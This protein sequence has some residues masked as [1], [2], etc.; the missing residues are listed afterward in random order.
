MLK[1]KT[2]KTSTRRSRTKIK[3]Q[4]NKNWS[5]N[6]NN[7]KDQTVV[8][9]G[10]ERRNACRWQIGIPMATRAALSVTKHDKI[11]NYLAKEYFWM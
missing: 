6:T 3:N 10:G 4:N 1:F 2:N 8:F 7:K 9:K 5:W 11:F